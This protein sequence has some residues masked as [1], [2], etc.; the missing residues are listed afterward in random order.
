ML[1]NYLTCLEFENCPD[2][3]A[4]CINTGILFYLGGC[5]VNALNFYQAV[6]LNKKVIANNI[7]LTCLH[8]QE[9]EIGVSCLQYAVQ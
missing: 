5:Y 6:T 4:I 8:L 1:D 7:A 2:R 3:E 9:F